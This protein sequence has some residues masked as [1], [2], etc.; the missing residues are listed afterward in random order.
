MQTIKNKER[1]LNR[2]GFSM[3]ELLAVIVILGILGTIAIVSISTI[4]TRAEKNHYKT[5]EKNMI[6]AAESYVQDNRNILP[7]EIGD[8]RT[9]T[10]Q[11][12]QSR[13]YIGEV[14][15]RSKAS[16]TT[17]EVTIFK[18]SQ[19]GYSYKVYLKC[20]KYETGKDQYDENGPTIDLKLN[21]NY[22]DPY[23]TY[24]IT[25]TGENKIISYS[26]QI[27]KSGILV[28]DSGSIPVSREGEI[29][30]KKESLKEYVPGEI[31]INF[32]ATNIYGYS[33]TKKVSGNIIPKAA[34]ECIIS[35]ATTNYTEADWRRHNSPVEVTIGCKDK[36][37]NGCAKEIFS[38]LF[39]DDTKTGSIE[40]VDNDGIKNSCTVGVYIDNTPPTK[41]VLKNNYENVWTNKDYTITATAKDETSGIKSFQYRYPNSNIPG[42]RNWHDYPNSSS[43]SGEDRT[44]TTPAFSEE[45]SEYVEIRACDYVGNCS[46]AAR[47]MIKIDKTAP[48]CTISR[49]ISSPNGQNGWYISNV[50]MNI[51]VTDNLGTAPTAAKSPVSYGI[52]TST[53]P[54]YTGTAS[55]IQSTDAKKATWYGYVKDEAGNTTKCSDTISVDKTAPTQ[56]VLNISGSN[57]TMTSSDSTSGIMAFEYRTYGTSGSFTRF[58]ETNK[59]TI[60]ATFNNVI[61]IRAVDYAGNVSGTTVTRHCNNSGGTLKYDDNKGWICIK[62]KIQ[63]DSTCTRE[64]TGTCYRN[65]CCPS[66]SHGSFNGNGHLWKPCSSGTMCSYP[67]SCTQTESY[68]CKVDG[69]PSGFSWYVSGS[70]CYKTAD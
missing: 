19:D 36:N 1:Y 24:A 26:Y 23:F 44:F 51:N 35:D 18:Y 63:V 62:D 48:T 38:Q 39:Y 27:Y 9:I 49:N 2:N 13:K 6:M 7:K 11:E 61:E 31:E 12:L 52:T 34:P 46:E 28:K 67:Y 14:L 16:C 21:K 47:S 69:C 40:I 30:L 66:S 64:T 8:T 65:D 22:T 56:P 57:V 41:P 59:A 3:V 60:T 4:L 70:T 10:L 43:N 15:D 55:A 33:S 5:Q 32:K 50:T 68:S 53:T 17:G 45:R 54:S 20:P 42:E 37:G 25:T 29:S 58:S